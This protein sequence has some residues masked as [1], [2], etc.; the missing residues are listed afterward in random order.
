MSCFFFI[1]LCIRFSFSFR[2]FLS[3]SFVLLDHTFINKFCVFLVFFFLL[4]QDYQRCDKT[5]FFLFYLFIFIIYCLESFFSFIFISFTFWLCLV[6]FFFLVCI[7]IDIYVTFRYM[8]LFLIYLLSLFIIL[9]SFFSI[10]FLYCL[11][12]CFIVWCLR[13]GP[14]PVQYRFLSF[15]SRCSLVWYTLLP[16]AHVH[17]TSHQVHTDRY[18]QQQVYVHTNPIKACQV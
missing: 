12:S 7:Y 11:T 4:R 15:W 2:V 1:W 8:F 6:I 17:L 16:H 18:S 13:F 10:V 5:V 14:P 9:F 3:R